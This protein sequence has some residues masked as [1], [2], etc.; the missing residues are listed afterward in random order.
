MDV[1]QNATIPDGLIVLQILN[2]FWAGFQ[3]YQSMSGALLDAYIMLPFSNGFDLWYWKNKGNGNN[4][5]SFIT[6]KLYYTGVFF[7]FNKDV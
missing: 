2:R 4:I 7:F 5:A 6:N 1:K 3:Y